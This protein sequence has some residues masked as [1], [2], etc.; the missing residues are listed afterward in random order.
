M[1]RPLIQPVI[2]ALRGNQVAA[3][4]LYAH[5]PSLRGIL[6]PGKMPSETVMREVEQRLV[7]ILNSITELRRQ[8]APDLEEYRQARRE[9][10]ILNNEYSA[11]LRQGRVAIIAWGRAHDRLASGVID[12]AEINVLGTARQAA[13]GVVPF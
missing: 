3:D 2:M 13:G 6:Q 9:L 7:F 8:I 1:A 4:S 10:G 12:P 11:A 5:Q